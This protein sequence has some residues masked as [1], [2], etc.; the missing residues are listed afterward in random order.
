MREIP[1][2]KSN[3]FFFKNQIGF[4]LIHVL[5][6]TLKNVYTRFGGPRYC[7]K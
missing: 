7:R 1:S 6:C 5:E 3:N 4:V 2:Y